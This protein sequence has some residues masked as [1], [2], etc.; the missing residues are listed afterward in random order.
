MSDKIYKT[1]LESLQ[2]KKDIKI[3]AIG[4]SICDGCASDEPGKKWSNGAL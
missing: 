4:D 3:V 1:F 2:E